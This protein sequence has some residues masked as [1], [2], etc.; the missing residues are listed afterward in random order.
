[1]Q[2]IKKALRLSRSAVLVLTVAGCEGTEFDPEIPVKND[3]AQDAVA[4][5][6]TTQDT[7]QDTQTDTT[8]DAGSPDA[9]D[10]TETGSETG[11]DA[12]EDAYA[13]AQDA[14]PDQGSDVRA[15][16][17]LDAPPD[18]T[19]DATG[20]APS[21]TAQDVAQDS[22]ADAAEDA[23]DSGLLC[24]P[25]DTRCVDFRP[26]LC[27]GTS[28]DSCGT[29]R[30]C[31][32]EPD[33]YT[34]TSDTATDTTTGREWWRNAVHASTYDPPAHNTFCSNLFANGRLATV[35]E[36]LAIVI[37][38]PDDAGIARCTPTVDQIAFR[39]IQV[40]TIEASDGCVNF[41][42]GISTSCSGQTL[43]FLCVR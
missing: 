39:D 3:A 19:G 11:L 6:D 5:P 22:P 15:D 37:G 8:L 20:D 12:S 23:Q 32:T 7:V 43:D 30:Q 33:R 13:D 35:A 29:C 17:P 41:T 2:P 28:W 31:C 42:Y 40:S 14:T 25:G 1:M 10:A 27:S 38:E 36:L 18:V 26:Q 4:Q 9:L 21:D 34:L 24:T 16:S